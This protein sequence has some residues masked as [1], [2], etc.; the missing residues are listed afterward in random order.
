MKKGEPFLFFS[1]DVSSVALCGL[2]HALEVSEIF[3]FLDDPV[4]K[5]WLKNHP[6]GQSPFLRQGKF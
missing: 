4:L 5:L 2:L 1:F 3:L 6:F